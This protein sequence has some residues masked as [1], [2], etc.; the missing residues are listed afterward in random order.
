[1]NNKF[2]LFLRG[3]DK[4]IPIVYVTT[5]PV[6]DP[7]PKII[8]AKTTLYIFI[9]I[10]DNTGIVNNVEDPI[11]RGREFNIKDSKYIYNI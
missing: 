7:M 2:L 1:M 4:K 9:P 3:F 5:F 6:A 10:T 8:D 11:D